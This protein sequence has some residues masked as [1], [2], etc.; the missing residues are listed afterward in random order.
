MIRTGPLQLEYSVL[1]LHPP[2][3]CPEL[4]GLRDLRGEITAEISDEHISPNQAVSLHKT[5]HKTENSCWFLL[6]AISSAAHHTSHRTEIL[7]TL[8]AFWHMGEIKSS[9]IRCHLQ[10]TRTIQECCWSWG[11]PW[12]WAAHYTLLF[13]VCNFTCFHMLSLETF[14]N[15]MEMM[16]STFK[17]ET[18]ILLYLPG[19]SQSIPLSTECS[20]I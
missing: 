15:S 8:N 1:W 14:C 10:R 16:G 5:L 2:G 13:S 18:Q 6:N 12:R 9:I 17:A 19:I 20:F 4:Q 3:P 11:E 7:I